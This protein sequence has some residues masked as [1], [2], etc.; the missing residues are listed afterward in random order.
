MIVG[1]NLRRSFSRSG[2]FSVAVTLWVIWK[3][4]RNIAL[5]DNKQTPAVESIQEIWSELIHTL[6]G[7]FDA[8][9]GLPE[10]VERQRSLFH[11]QWS[12][13]PFY[14][15]ISA[16]LLWHFSPPKWLFAPP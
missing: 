4:G 7:Q 11:Q 5:F 1:F 3:A 9:Q 14:S 15:R 6:K 10:S 8:F 16:Q 13:F 2:N 12:F